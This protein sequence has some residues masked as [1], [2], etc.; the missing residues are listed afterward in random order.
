M[1]RVALHNAIG[2]SIEAL[3]LPRKYSLKLHTSMSAQVVELSE[4]VRDMRNEICLCRISPF[5]AEKLRNAFQAVIRDL[6]LLKH[7]TVLFENMP[8]DEIDTDLHIQVEDDVSV[9]VDGS[10]SINSE[11]SEHIEILQSLMAVPTRNLIYNM[12]DLLRSCNST[13]M[14][15]LGAP[16][17][18]GGTT[19]TDL[20][21]CLQELQTVIQAYDT[22]DK[23]VTGHE[24]L[25]KSYASDLELV[26]I[27]LFMHPV[28]QAANSILSLGTMVFEITSYRANGR[29]RLF[30][31]SYPLSKA[32]HRV[33]NFCSL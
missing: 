5:D 6:M 20:E 22:A 4:T 9:T 12:S 11:D 32:I 10:V 2:L 25:P 27:F 7:D 13:L 33:S 17:F 28:R 21:S 19:E 23:A 18:A 31:P 16:E 15:T 1:Y 29:R 30:F 3:V 8:P 26:E 24:G 14:R